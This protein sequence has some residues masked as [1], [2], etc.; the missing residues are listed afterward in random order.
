[1]NFNSRFFKQGFKQGN[2]KGFFNFKKEILNV[3]KSNTHFN[4]FVMNRMQTMN[5]ISII[6]SC[7]MTNAMIMLNNI[8][9]FSNSNNT[10][11]LENETTGKTK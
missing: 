3:N 9:L 10:Q 7:K 1:M 11:I 5:Y 4:L 2:F 6:N 8:T